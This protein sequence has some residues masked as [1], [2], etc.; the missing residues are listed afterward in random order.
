MLLFTKE[1]HDTK[2]MWKCPSSIRCC[3]S[4]PQP[5]EHELPPIVTHW[6][7]QGLNNTILGGRHRSVDLSTPSILPSHVWVPST[8]SMLFQFILFKLY[9]CHLNWN[10]KRMKINKKRPGLA[11]LKNNT[12]FCLWFQICTRGCGMKRTML[13]LRPRTEHSLLPQ[14]LLSHRIRR[15]VI[16]VT[17]V[18]RLGKFWKI[19]VTDFLSKVAQMSVDFW[20]YF[21]KASLFK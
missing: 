5:P 7:D 21:W 19:L 10:V 18:T 13:Y 2:L 6:K 20:S 14:M 9:I 17:S 3:D 4:N 15:E 12:I 11:H 1:L 8:P 16:G